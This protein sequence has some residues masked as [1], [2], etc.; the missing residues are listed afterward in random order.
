MI[1]DEKLKL[2]H[3]KDQEYRRAYYNKNKEIIQKY[4][5][6][7]Y[8]ARKLRSNQEVRPYSVEWKGSK[9]KELKIRRGEFKVTFE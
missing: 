6:D 5:R 1:S 8:R 2:K 4:Q 3:L 9:T 7:Y